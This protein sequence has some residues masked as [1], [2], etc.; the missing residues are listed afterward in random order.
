[1]IYSGDWNVT[2]NPK[3]DHKNYMH[4]NFE[5]FIAKQHEYKAEQ[6]IQIHTDIQ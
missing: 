4:I 2:I 1:M 6:Q 5:M 3:L